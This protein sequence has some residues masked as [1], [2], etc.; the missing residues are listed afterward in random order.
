MH[1]IQ[2]FR[3][4]LL[5][6]SKYKY[7]IPYKVRSYIWVNLLIQIRDFEDSLI[8]LLHNI[9]LTRT[10]SNIDLN[11][12]IV[13]YSNIPKIIY[14]KCCGEHFGCVVV[15]YITRH[16]VLPPNL[17]KYLLY[18]KEPTRNKNTVPPQNMGFYIHKYGV[19]IYPTNYHKSR[20][21]W[22]GAVT[23]WENGYIN[24]PQDCQF[25]DLIKSVWKFLDIEMDIH[26]LNY[27]SSLLK[28]LTC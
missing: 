8:D 20:L 21:L 27:R 11:D 5:N 16:H 17:R 12:L 10:L 7:S 19:Q 25:S 6:S 15:S 14:I 4:S 3:K 18:A 26:Q 24:N 13:S 28:L 22:M 1:T 2:T 23:S 9:K